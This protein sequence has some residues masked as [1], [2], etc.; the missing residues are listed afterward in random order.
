MIKEKILIQKKIFFFVFLKECDLSRIH[1]FEAVLPWLYSPRV[2]EALPS[3]EVPPLSPG[4]SCHPARARPYSCWQR[5]KQPFF[6]S[7]LMQ[8]AGKASGSSLYCMWTLFR[9]SSISGPHKPGP[10]SHLSGWA[11]CPSWPGD[12]ISTTGTGEGWPREPWSEGF[13][14]V[15]SLG[16]TSPSPHSAWL[17]TP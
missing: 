10:A 16:L 7:A 2:C 1:S 4:R 6:P 3:A 8:A 5:G 12:T 11:L 13:S 17:N 9:P 14:A 15:L